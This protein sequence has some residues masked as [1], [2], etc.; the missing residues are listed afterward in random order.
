MIKISDLK[1]KYKNHNVL[2]IKNLSLNTQKTT[3]LLGL[4]GS[5][6]STLL[7]IIAH[8]IKPN[9][10]EI[11]IWGKDKLSLN[12]LKEIS[13]LLPEPFLLK[14][15]VRENFKFALNTRGKLHEFNER[16]GEA[17]ELV[18]LGWEFLDKRHFEL[19]SGQNKRIAFAL[20]LSLRSRLN[21]LDEPTNAVDLATSKLFSK[22]ILYQKQ[23]YNSGFII[24]THDEKW[25]SAISNESVFLHEG[26]VSEFELKNIFNANF[27]VIDFGTFRLNL[28]DEMKNAAKIAINQN[29]INLSK[30]AF[31]NANFGLLHSISLINKDEILI[32]IK[33]GDFL[34]KC[35]KKQNEITGL[36]TGDFIY[37]EVPKNAFLSL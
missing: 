19:S 14:R 9:F 15:S 26:K 20:V 17:L 35:V 13:I 10:G 33:T 30:I 16:V 34:I 21:L 31:E 6:K 22:A 36:K 7:K 24:A 11:K 5:G 27:G 28:P 29:L 32:K 4:N 37:F 1:F 23:R 12:E 3:A 18:G 25:I 2:D 8:L